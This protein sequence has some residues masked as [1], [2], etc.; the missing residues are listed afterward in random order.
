M[1]KKDRLSALVTKVLAAIFLASFWAPPAFG[2]VLYKRGRRNWGGQ[3][4]KAWFG[5]RF[6][7]LELA[8]ANQRRG[9][10]PARLFFVCVLGFFVLPNQ[11]PSCPP[12][13][14]AAVWEQFR[15]SEEW[16][17]FGQAALH[18]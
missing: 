8:R 2:G 11:A 6:A 18:S 15:L 16:E 12:D 13:E 7:T 3:V 17:S 1:T 10:R 4:A 5:G 9:I 14:S